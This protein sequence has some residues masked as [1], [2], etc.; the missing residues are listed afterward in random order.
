M[1]KIWFSLEV[2]RSGNGFLVHML[3]HSALGIGGAA[4]ELSPGICLTFYSTQ[5]QRLT[6]SRAYPL[7]SCIRALFELMNMLA[8]GFPSRCM[9]TGLNLRYCLLHLYF[10]EHGFTERF[11]IG[12]IATAMSDISW[13]R[14]FKRTI[15]HKDDD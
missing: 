10:R 1:K 4:P 14:R 13:H 9:A 5:D 11:N 6:A 8:M 15:A 2:D 7:G 12:D 3:G